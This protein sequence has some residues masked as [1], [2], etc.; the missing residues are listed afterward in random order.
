[1]SFKTGHMDLSNMIF[2]Q[3]DLQKAREY[4]FP[5]IEKVDSSWLTKPKGPLAKF[6]NSD[7][8]YATCFLIAIASV[9]G[10]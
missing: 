8:P 1:M 4:L 2:T 10:I 3:G 9:L 6:W 5:L 7:S